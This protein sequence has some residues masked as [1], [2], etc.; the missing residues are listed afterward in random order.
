MTN[1]TTPEII[2]RA[3]AK[4]LGLPRYFTGHPC[5]SGH[6]RERLVSNG[7][8]LDCL[9]EKQKRHYAL[10]K[11]DPGRAQQMRDYERE[12]S[13][14]R[15]QDAD[16]RARQA[17]QKAERYREDSAFREAML[18]RGKAWREANREK[19]RRLIREWAAKNPA[20]LAEKLARYRA[21]KLRRT[22]DI[23]QPELA[24]ENREQIR[25]MYEEAKSRTAQTGVLHHVDHIVP[26]QGKT[27]SGL[28]VWWNL[29]VIPANDNWRKGNR[30]TA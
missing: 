19:L 8:C 11:S 17:E 16:Y 23:A 15:R 7:V 25:R 4:A 27:V 21:A 9:R 6:V 14:K 29:Q 1:K 12:R 2:S 13:V 26:L 24:A 22:L 18:A 28:H 10:A 20:R 3:E 30:L 5:K